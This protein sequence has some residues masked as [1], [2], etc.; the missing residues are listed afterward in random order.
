MPAPRSVLIP[1]SASRSSAVGC[2]R[3]GPTL[4]STCSGR[5]APAITLPTAGC[6]A[7]PPSGDVEDADAAL[8]GVLLERL[9]AVP[10]GAREPVRLG[11]GAEPAAV[12]RLLAAAVLPGQQ[13]V[14]EREVGE[15]A[16]P[17][18]ARSAGTSSSSAARL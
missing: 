16:R 18:G 12:G 1:A 7:S 8:G 15:Q 5:V 6:A 13:A 14:G 4:A 17:R 9:D 10:V 2:Q 11:V 3:P